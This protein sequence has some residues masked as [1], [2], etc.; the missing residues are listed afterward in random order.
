MKGAP[1]L[2]VSDK[3]G[4]IS[5]HSSLEACGMKAGHFFRMSSRDLVKLPA[6]SRLFMLPSRAPV[7]YDPRSNNFVTRGGVYGVAAFIRPGF[8]A[9]Y[10][11]SYTEDGAPK[12]LPLFSYAA[13]AFYRGALYAASVLVDKDRRHDGRFIDISSVRKNSAKFKKIFPGNR[14]VGHLEKCALVYGCPNAQNFFLSRYEA[15]L[16]VSPSCNAG[17]L[18]CISFQSVK[19][20]IC[21]SQ[22]RIKFIPAPEELAEIALFHI[23]NVKYPI[24]SFGQGCE[25]EP[26]LRWK[27]IEASIR[28]I[29]KI[30]RKGTINMNTNGSMPRVLDRLREAGLDSVRISM[31]SCRD[32]FY[33]RYYA[34]RGYSFKNV[35]AF[36]AKAKSAGLFV[37]LNY[38]TMPGFTDSLDEAA[39]LGRLISKYGVDML[40]WR[41]LNYDPLLYFKKMRIQPAVSEML[42]IEGMIKRLKKLYP[43][44]M[45]GYFNSRE[46][47]SRHR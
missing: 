46:A 14:L 44:L 42:G 4:N 43:K 1:K 11:P 7:G 2:L 17:C 45:M 20:K 19:G 38:L 6:G 26:L 40:Q 10:S 32:T 22:P 34:P 16:P 5:V 13:C 27:T 18:G 21:A 28:I 15:P 33:T 25:G 9:T 24:V 36:L 37:S 31:N 35:L 47:A 29:R 12:P 41:N 8:T 23:K 3:I 39:A 30:T